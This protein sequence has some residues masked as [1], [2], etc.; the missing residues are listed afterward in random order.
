M[1]TPS[2]HP[3]VVGGMIPSQAKRRGGFSAVGSLFSDSLLGWF[4]ERTLFA[5]LF[6]VTL[7]N[8]AG[9]GSAKAEA[10]RHDSLQFHVVFS[11]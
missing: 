6:S 5:Q 7:K 8:Q 9:I 10:V 11:G 2:A 1:K 4:R 3:G